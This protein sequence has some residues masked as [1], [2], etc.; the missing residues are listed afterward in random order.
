MEQI[1][2]LKI[3]SR[4]QGKSEEKYLVLSHHQLVFISV[5]TRDFTGCDL[6]ET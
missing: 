5:Y 4:Q 2:L 1:I 6:T 3:F